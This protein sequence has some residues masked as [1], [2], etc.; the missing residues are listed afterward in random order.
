M[1]YPTF[2]V[3]IITLYAAFSDRSFYPITNPK[4]SLAAKRPLDGL[5]LC[6]ELPK[7]H[8][9]DRGCLGFVER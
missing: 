3:S 4:E 5:L 1:C 6:K 8:L 7:G 2:E 9:G